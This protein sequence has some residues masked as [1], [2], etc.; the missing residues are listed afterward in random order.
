MKTLS[1]LELH[2]EVKTIS[3]NECDYEATQQSNL[4]FHI[5]SKYKSLKYDCYQCE[6]QYAGQ[7][8]RITYIYNMKEG[9][10]LL[11]TIQNYRIV[12][13]KLFPIIR[14]TFMS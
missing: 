3:C 2:I 14:Y 13:L 1:A 4:Y 6:Y 7:S 9:R 5:K 11:T 12:I 8:T 10:K